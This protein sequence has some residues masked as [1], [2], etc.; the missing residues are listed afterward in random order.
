MQQT[1]PE[2]VRTHEWILAALDLSRRKT[3]ALMRNDLGALEQCLEEEGQLFSRKP[4]F[5][6]GTLRRSV[7]LELRTNNKRNRNLVQSGAEFSQAM[8]DA[9]HPPTTYGDR[10]SACGS[11]STGE[12]IF[13]VTC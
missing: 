2:E 12:P 4:D 7:V 9:I 3:A 5:K 10:L 13:S 8:L 1:N 11:G 6:P